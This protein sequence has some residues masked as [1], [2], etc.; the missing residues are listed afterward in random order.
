MASD[1][2]VIYDAGIANPDRIVI[3]H[4]AA[5]PNFGLL[6]RDQGPDRMIFQGA[7]NPVLTVGIGDG[8]VGIGT[9]DPT[10]RLEVHGDVR[11]TGDIFLT[12]AD[13]AEDFDV[14]GAEDIEP[15]TVVV[16]D[17]DGKGLSQARWAYDTR[18]AGV[19]SGAGGLSPG[20]TL[21]KRGGRRLPLAVMGKVYCKADASYGAIAV[22]DLLTTSPTPGHAM[23][24]ADRVRAF[25][26]IIGKALLPLPV[27]R[28]LVPM[29]VALQ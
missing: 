11:V 8:N 12:N 24:A 16:L 15:G 1:T 28:D 20:L 14:A 7:G 13:C 6:F 23:R 25:G 3:E 27:G 18:V 19:I 10:T 5:F 29:L 9:A 2:F 4:S 17:A 26:A 21:D 22:G